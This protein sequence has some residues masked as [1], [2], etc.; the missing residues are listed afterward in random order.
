MY[1]ILFRR[2]IFIG[3]YIYVEVLIKFVKKN[4]I[5]YCIMRMMKI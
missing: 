4:V 2:Q 1:R 3:R 5:D